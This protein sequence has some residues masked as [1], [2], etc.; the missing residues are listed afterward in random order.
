MLA[1]VNYS[2]GTHTRTHTPS[3][4][5]TPKYDVNRE[6]RTVNQQGYLIDTDLK[7]LKQKV[8]SLLLKIASVGDCLT[9]MFVPGFAIQVGYCP[10][11]DGKRGP[12]SL[13][14][15]ALTCNEQTENAAVCFCRQTVSQTTHRKYIFVWDCAGITCRCH[16]PAPGNILRG[17]VTYPSNT[18]PG[19]TGRGKATYPSNTAPGNIMRGKAAY[20][21][22]TALGNIM[23]GKAT[24]PSDTAPGN[25]M[26]GKATYGT[27]LIQR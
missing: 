11:R 20:P 4:A 13:A 6:K 10:F 2:Q 1:P 18:A 26:R 25:I 3:H 23:R 14:R 16:R 7:V 9:D 17:K 21:S 22:N 19:N 27:H 8:F 12:L 15:R 24:Y 5:R